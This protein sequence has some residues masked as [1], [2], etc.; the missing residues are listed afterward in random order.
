MILKY[1]FRVKMS[2]NVDVFVKLWIDF[3]VLLKYYVFFVFGSGS[4]KNR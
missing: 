4:C 2:M 1:Y 3:I